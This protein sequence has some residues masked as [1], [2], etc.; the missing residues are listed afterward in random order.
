MLEQLSPVCRVEGD[1][2]GHIPEEGSAIA[3]VSKAKSRTISAQ[4]KRA[5][6]SER[7]KVESSFKVSI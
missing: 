1:Q 7:R 3:G 5:D 6:V 2:D 4:M